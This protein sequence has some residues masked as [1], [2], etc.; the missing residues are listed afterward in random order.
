MFPLFF[1][2]Q[3][4]WRLDFSDFGFD[5]ELLEGIISI[6]YKSPTD[7]Q[8]K[9]IPEILKGKDMIASAQTGTGKT[10]AFL[11]PLI[12]KMIPLKH[13]DHVKALVIVP[14]R[15][16]A[17]QI[18]QQ[19]EG[20]SYFTPVSSIAVY[21]GGD[22]DL[23]AKERSAFKQGADMIICTPGRML[24]HLNQEY[25][26]FDQLKYLVLD[27]ADRMLDMGFIDDIMRI[28]SHIPKERQNL[29]FSATMPAKIQE[30]ANKVLK[31]PVIIKI[32][33]SRPPDKIAQA[34]FILLR[35]PKD[36]TRYLYSISTPA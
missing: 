24:S 22:G 10:G 14:T 19:M 28:I 31:D 34:A 7:I 13:D 4:I 21:G 35:E 33:L 17:I 32:A 18:D 3:N 25:V 29:L 26:K 30:L 27:E 23:F 1:S 20:F 11:L 12:E 9:A 36:S 16:L 6:G 15:E 2:H 8:E 5:P